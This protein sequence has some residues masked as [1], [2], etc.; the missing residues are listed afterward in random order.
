MALAMS[1]R[2]WRELLTMLCILYYNTAEE[3]SPS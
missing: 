3:Y 2:T 1:T